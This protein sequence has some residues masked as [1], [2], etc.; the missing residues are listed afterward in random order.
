MSRAPRVSVLMPVYNAA[1]DLPAAL[2][3]VLAQSWRDF[4]FVIVDDGSEDE[5]PAIV[6]ARRDPRIRHLRRPHGGFAAALN[7]GLDEARGEYVA[8]MDADDVCEPERLAEQV[9]FMDAHP[10]IGISGAFVRALLPDGSAR[11]WIFPCDPA[12]LRAGLLF[13]PGLAHPTAI[14]RR[15]ALEQHGLRYDARYPRVEDWDLWR[16]AALHFELGNLP[17]VLLGYR[18]HATRMSSAHGEEQK[19]MGRAIQDELLAPL[20]LADHPL[21]R[22]HGPVS[23][24]ALDCGG[25]DAA[26]LAD[27]AAW[28]EALR[29]ANARC[30]GYDPRALDAFLADRLL[31]VLNANRHLR[32][33]ALALL[34][35]SGWG[36][37]VSW[38]AL[39]RLLLKGALPVR[40]GAPSS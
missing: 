18:V 23:L 9:R 33:P 2:D 3:S 36:R 12:V 32:G 19:R 11:R 5:S 13:E 1:K 37:R 14:L 38:P 25:R 34:L 26:F 27:V 39:L 10:R 31:L 7:H 4:E 15:A 17:R 29:A 30:G 40:A 16:R 35:R 21:R 8:R 6:A 20:G 28:F 24:A 22:V